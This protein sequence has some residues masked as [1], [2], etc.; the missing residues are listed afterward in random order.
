MGEARSSRCKG[1]ICSRIVGAGLSFGEAERRDDGLAAFD[2]FDG[3][4]V[5]A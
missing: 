3:W 1:L 2:G 5:T 4:L